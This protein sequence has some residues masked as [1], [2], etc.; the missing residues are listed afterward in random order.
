MSRLE[1]DTGKKYGFHRYEISNYARRDMMF[2]TSV[3]S[4]AGLS[5]LLGAASLVDNAAFQY[6]GTSSHI[7]RSVHCLEITGATERSTM[8]ETMFLGLRL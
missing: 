7:W 3:T 8:E 5:G 2:I 4:S 1:G 6:G